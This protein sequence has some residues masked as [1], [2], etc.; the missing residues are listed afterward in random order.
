MTYEVR[1]IARDDEGTIEADTSFRG[2]DL[3]EAVG[4]ATKGVIEWLCESNDAGDMTPLQVLLGI[5]DRF[6]TNG[7]TFQ[8]DELRS[9]YQILARNE[10]DAEN[11]DEERWAESVKAE[12][13][14]LT[15]EATK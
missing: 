3:G 13:C 6:N 14:R 4:Q 1:I 12:L 5:I 15:E 10:N 2:G 8:R 7:V 9:L 11:R